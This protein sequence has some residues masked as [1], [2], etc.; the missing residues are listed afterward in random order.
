MLA[1]K[2]ELKK[3]A[4]TIDYSNNGNSDSEIKLDDVAY[5]NKIWPLLGRLDTC[6]IILLY[7]STSNPRVIDVLLPLLTFEQK[8]RL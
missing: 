1:M 5:E 3:P 7:I 6:D 8:T 2:T 4:I